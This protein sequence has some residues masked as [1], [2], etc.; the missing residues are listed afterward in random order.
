[1][2][3]FTAEEAR[4]IMDLKKECT[5]KTLTMMRHMCDATL[6]GASERGQHQMT[7]DIPTTMWGREAF[8]QHEIG[9]QLAE[10]LYE[11]GFDV[12][13]TTNK[14]NISWNVPQ[15]RSN[16][17]TQFDSILS[18]PLASSAMITDQASNPSSRFT[19]QQQQPLKSIVP[20]CRKRK[21]TK[22]QLN[23]NV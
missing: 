11:D 7:F 23:I 19:F 6:K 1:M 14:L 8:D 15:S 10:Q 21:K 18:S 4:D 17:K 3:R 22:R 12:T 20:N 2:S 16:V 9:R 13:G 5:E